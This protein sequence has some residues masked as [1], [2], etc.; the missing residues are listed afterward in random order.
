MYEALKVLD[1]SSPVAE[2]LR[3]K[4]EVLDSMVSTTYEKIADLA[5]KENKSLV[6][7]HMYEKLLG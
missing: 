7:L 3:T 4:S 6:S 1:P 5:N 2:G